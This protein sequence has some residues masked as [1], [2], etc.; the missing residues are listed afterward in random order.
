[1]SSVQ[2]N[3][4][5]PNF[6]ESMQEMFGQ[7]TRKIS[8][9]S[10]AMQGNPLIREIDSRFDMIYFNLIKYLLNDVPKMYLQIL[11]SLDSFAFKKKGKFNSTD[12]VWEVMNFIMGKKVEKELCVKESILTYKLLLQS[13][14]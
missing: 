8:K 13:T 5:V 3:N 6:H 14:K 9:M 4:P 2:N 10:A 1:M 12:T 7:K 11:K